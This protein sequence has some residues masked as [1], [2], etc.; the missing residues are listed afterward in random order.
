MLTVFF[1][2]APTQVA[3]Y[4]F[5][6]PVFINGAPLKRTVVRAT[7]LD[8]ILTLSSR[9]CDFGRSFLQGS[10]PAAQFFKLSSADRRE[11]H[12]VLLKTVLQDGPSP[13]AIRLLPKGVAVVAEHEF[14]LQPLESCQLEVTF[15]PSVL[16]TCPT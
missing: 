10:A 12:K 8:S 2:F 14:S 15:Q 1:E 11:P 13:F 7:G 16:G 5:N 6:L 4:E 9:C 3:S